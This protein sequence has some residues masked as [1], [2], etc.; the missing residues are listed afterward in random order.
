VDECC[1]LDARGRTRDSQRRPH[2]RIARPE[3]DIREGVAR[4]PPAVSS[5]RVIGAFSCGYLLGLVPS[6]EIVA[7]AASRDGLD[8]RSAGSGNPG[9]MN[10]YRLLG[11][12]AGVAVAVADVGKGVAACVAGRLVAGGNGA[13]AAGV[14]A[15]AAHC[16]P[17][18]RSLD[19]GLGA[20]TSFGQCLATFPVFAPVD[21]AVATAV[22]RFP[23]LRRPAAAALLVSSTCWIAAGALWWK[24]RLPNLWG[25]EPTVALPFA[26]AASAAVIASRALLVLQRRRLT[27]RDLA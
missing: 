16:Y 14:G 3:S 22:P 24:R 27:A 20:A 10:V 26:N 15:V 21:A 6:A 11:R 1:A 25:P 13:H 5:V 23:G 8:L 17:L 19:G 12:R 2:V 9:A 4:L 18:N 7:R